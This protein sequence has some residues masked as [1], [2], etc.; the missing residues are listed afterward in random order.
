LPH[1]A[2]HAQM[3]LGLNSSRMRLGAQ[4]TIRSRVEPLLG[5]STGHYHAASRR[6]SARIG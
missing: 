6:L 3:T 2:R 4:V 1:P 5:S